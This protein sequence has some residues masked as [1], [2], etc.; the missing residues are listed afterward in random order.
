MRGA[1]DGQLPLGCR[2]DQGGQQDADVAENGEVAAKVD[3]LAQ[4]RLLDL[5]GHSQ[6]VSATTALRR[7]DGVHPDCLHLRSDEFAL[8]GLTSILWLANQ[9]TTTP[10]PPQ[11]LVIYVLEL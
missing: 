11:I 1:S 9:T 7:P 5:H 10:S 6:G 3:A 8:R 2:R 4:V